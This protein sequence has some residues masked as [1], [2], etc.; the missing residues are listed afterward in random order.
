MFPAGVSLLMVVTT[1]VII[2]LLLM[3]AAT[4]KAEPPGIWET[5]DTMPANI[6]SRIDTT[7][8]QVPRLPA[9][10]L[11][12]PLLRI[13]G[14]FVSYIFNYRSNID[15]PFSEKNIAQHNIAGTFNL[16]AG[17][18]LPLNVIYWLRKSNSDLF[19]DVADVQVQFDAAAFRN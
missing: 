16:L 5:K 3:P 7:L 15:T 2:G 6:K 10:L 9:K 17:N 1:I 11:S 8:W 14:G 19:R 13:K 4:L 12:K 18:I